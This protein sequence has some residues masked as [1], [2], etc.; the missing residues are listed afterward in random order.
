MKDLLRSGD[1]ATT[2]EKEEGNL[3]S[4]PERWRKEWREGGKT[5]RTKYALNILDESGEFSED[6]TL[7][8]AGLDAHIN[9]VDDV[10]DSEDLDPKEQVNMQ[11][12]AAKGLGHAYSNIP[13]DMQRDIHPIIDDYIDSVYDIP[14][15]EK[16]YRVELEEADTPEQMA[17]VA[18]KCYGVRSKVVDGFFEAGA[19]YFDINGRRD[20]MREDTRNLLARVQ[21]VKDL[22]DIDEDLDDDDLGP[23]ATIVGLT[24]NLEEAEETIEELYDRFEYSEE[25]QEE[26]GQVL[27]ELGPSREE[28]SQQIPVV[29]NAMKRYSMR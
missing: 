19:E 25:G 23:S 9:N 4:M 29:E 11:E 3:A 15:Q 5:L 10:L 28:I 7:A 12:C 13:D 26:Y 2:W 16:R 21:M 1:I 22:Y 6:I 17:E 20:R 8:L 27:D 14:K 24:D 18:E